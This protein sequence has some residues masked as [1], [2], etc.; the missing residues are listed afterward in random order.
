MQR[1]RCAQHLL[2][3]DG[4]QGGSPVTYTDVH[5]VLL[6]GIHCC[7]RRRWMV[8]GM[9]MTL[10]KEDVVA[11]AFEEVARSVVFILCSAVARE[12]PKIQGRESSSFKSSMSL[13]RADHFGQGQGQGKMCFVARATQR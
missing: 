4:A 10:V 6:V 5:L 11:G 1:A 13:A 12:A 3:L 9:Q 8:W 7:R 2:L